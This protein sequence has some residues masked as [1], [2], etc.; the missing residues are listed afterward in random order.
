MQMALPFEAAPAPADVSPF[1][2][3]RHRRARRYIVR[4]DARGRVRVT[5]PRGG[6]RRE[7]DRFARHHMEWI[8]TRLA[9]VRPSPPDV[10]NDAQRR[11]QARAL[12]E[13]RLRALAAEHGVQVTRV[14][15]G[16]QQTRWG[17]C[18]RDWRISLNWRLLKMPEWVR[19]YVLVHEL[20]HLRRMDHSPVYWRLVEAAYPRY[21][22]AQQWLHVHGPGLR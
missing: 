20:M 7:A 16:N 6:S 3:V 17:S 22:D 13:P 2:F 21:K 5:I 18:S 9:E 1:V 15:I 19:D 14:R 12:L 4:I 10:I 8:R 11:E